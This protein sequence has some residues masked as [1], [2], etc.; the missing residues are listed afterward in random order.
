ML[1]TK[2]LDADN[3]SQWFVLALS[4]T[5]AGNLITVG[6]IANLIVIEKAK[7]YGIFIS[8]REHAKIGI[9]VTIV[10]F[11]ITFLYIAL[12]M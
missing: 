8:F 7:E 10:S 9:P 6:S 11:V 3:H 12:R 4:S 2:F 5:F 1:V